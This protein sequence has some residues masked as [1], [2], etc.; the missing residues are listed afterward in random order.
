MIGGRGGGSGTLKEKRL[1]LTYRVSFLRLA[2]DTVLLP[3]SSS[4]YIRGAAFLRF[5]GQVVIND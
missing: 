2:S 5:C 4:K 1:S 3:V